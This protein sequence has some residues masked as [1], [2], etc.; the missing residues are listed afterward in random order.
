MTDEP[1]TPDPADADTVEA[2]HATDDTVAEGTAQEEP[3]R[4]RGLA[5]TFIVVGTIIGFLAVFA[6][7]VQRQ[8]LN[9]DN[10]T[11]T[12]SQL[13]ANPAIRTAVSGFLVD[14]LYANVDVQG[15]LRNA[16]PQQFKGLAGPA[17]GGLR[18]VA[19]NVADEALQR[20]RV[21]A[22]W[23]QANRQAH[24]QLLRVLKGG[25]S[26]VQTNNGVVALDLGALLSDISSRTGVGG[27][28]A[29]KLPPG[30]AKITI[31]KSDQL[32]TA[33]NVAN[34]LK[35]LAII[36]TVLSLGCY[37]L[38][39]WL[40]HGWR[41]EALRAAGVGFVIAGVLALVVRR[42]AGSQ[43]VDSLATTDAVRPAVQATWQIATELLVSVATAAI[44][45][46]IVAVLA[47]W[48][49]GPTSWAAGL[50]RALSPY[51]REPTYAW[52]GFAI[53][54]L[55]LLVWAP[56]QALRQPLTALILIVL[57]AFGF[58]VLRR[59]AAREFP[60]SER[61]IGL[62]LRAA[63]GRVGSNG[64]RG[65]GG[66]GSGGVAVAASGDAS[67]ATTVAS[68]TVEAP[69][70][71]VA[72]AAAMDPLERLEKAAALHERGVLTDDEFAAEKNAILAAQ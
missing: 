50:R 28:L 69:T 7:W 33:Q 62:D 58:E 52:G 13:L 2:A 6:I 56:T 39:I 19:G 15:E 31:L 67:A 46:G 8:A 21:Q 44:I 40:G 17:A 20:P 18:N 26:A 27:R 70:V 63:L 34:A 64:V 1:T 72:R 5:M 11:S 16:L 45:Y 66:E 4:R 57:L 49:A 23:E 35:P 41:R 12:S 60:E 59:Q 37:A 48:L 68:P 29:G 43:V 71:P 14:Q 9:T 55:L 10:W 25:G 61:R 47:A 54:V 42:F 22:L 65:G 38:A 30:A 24:T 36:L 51:L 53:V 3:T 32:K